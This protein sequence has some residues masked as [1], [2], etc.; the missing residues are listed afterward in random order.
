MK[1]ENYEKI[2][3][4]YLNEYEVIKVEQ[5][6]PESEVPTL[7]RVDMRPRKQNWGICTF[8]FTDHYITSPKHV[9]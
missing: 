8:I 1:I 7:V 9:M 6:E 3:R 2:L 4:L 5:I